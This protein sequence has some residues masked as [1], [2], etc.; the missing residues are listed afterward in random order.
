MI[1][2][3]LIVSFIAAFVLSGIGSALLNVS[4]VRARHASEEGDHA[5]DRL[6]QLLETRNELHHAVTV[7]HHLCALAAFACCVILL[8]RWFGPWGWLC[9]LAVVL[10]I[11]LVGVEFVPK[12]LFRR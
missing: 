5:A 10:P 11:F 8:L 4:R 7:L 2:A 3:I 9:S 6:A 12:L 1:W